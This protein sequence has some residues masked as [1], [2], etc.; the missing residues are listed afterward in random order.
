MA[1]AARRSLGRIKYLLLR[2]NTVVP[3][4]AIV[5]LSGLAY[6]PATPALVSRNRRFGRAA[7]QCSI[8]Q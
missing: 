1:R 3:A 2:L 8:V 4:A 7:A 5:A 6:V